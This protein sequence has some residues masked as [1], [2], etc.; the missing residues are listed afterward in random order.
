MSR[1]A[2]LLSLAF[3]TF[4]AQAE[5]ID[6]LWLK[7]IAHVQE[8]KKWVAQD[9]DSVDEANM[10][11]DP[12]KTVTSKL[13]LSGWKDKQAV[14]DTIQISP[15]ADPSK[16]TSNKKPPAI[17]IGNAIDKLQDLIFDPETFPKRQDNQELDGQ[18]W[19][20]FQFE[21]AQLGQKMAVK[22]WI[23]AST[24]CMYR[25]ESQ[26]HISMM[27][28]GRIHTQFDKDEKNHCF[29]KQIDEKIDI[30]VPFKNGKMNLK[31]NPKNWI[32]R[33]V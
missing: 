25:M 30:L 28:D 31:Q 6:P 19:T 13:H 24:G 4:S 16:A 33:P 14:Y 27:G 20:L 9:I 32:L 7:T 5:T 3:S 21:Y 10:G 22:V 29:P 23:D 8:L 18:T 26:F 12:S 15:P 17:A 11:S 1:L 2:L